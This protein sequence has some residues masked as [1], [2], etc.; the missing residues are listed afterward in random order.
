MVS[1]P[2][3]SNDEGML[4]GQ[5]GL[6]PVILLAGFAR[7]TAAGMLLDVRGFLDLAR[8]I[9]LQPMPLVACEAEDEVEED[10]E[11]KGVL[12]FDCPLFREES[13]RAGT[14]GNVYR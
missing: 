5:H 9:T 7:T 14:T 2:E 10:G 4:A 3:A 8:D 6:K 12:A 13:G 1:L 11:R